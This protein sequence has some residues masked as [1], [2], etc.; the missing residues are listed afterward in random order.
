MGV[1]LIMVRA[2]IESML[3]RHCRNRVRFC[4]FHVDGGLGLPLLTR[5]TQGEAGQPIF[6]QHHQFEIIAIEA[7]EK[8]FGCANLAGNARHGPIHAGAGSFLGAVLINGITS[9]L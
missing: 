4:P 2:Q 3:L 6:G 5:F 9:R 1:G 8:A 7:F